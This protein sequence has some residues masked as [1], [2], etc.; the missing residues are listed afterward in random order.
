MRAR[1]TQRWG[2]GLGREK[3]RARKASSWGALQTTGG[4]G[5]NL[6][7]EL[8]EAQGS[9]STEACSSRTAGCRVAGPSGQD[10]GKGRPER[11]GLLGFSWQEMVPL[12]ARKQ[13]Q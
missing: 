9:S 7:S 2:G 6:N 13:Q 1:N 11:R 5:F 3:A 8:G 4:S 10:L 12:E